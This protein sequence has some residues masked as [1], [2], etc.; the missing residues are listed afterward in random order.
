[1]SSSPIPSA[2]PPSYDA[3]L[4]PA[5]GA[6]G[7]PGE[8]KEAK[9]LDAAAEGAPQLPGEGELAFLKDRITGIQARP[10]NQGFF[11]QLW[12]ELKS[13][14]GRT[15]SS[16]ERN[17]KARRILQEP[18]Q[19]GEG[20]SSDIKGQ[21]ALAERAVT[22]AADTSKWKFQLER[23]RLLLIDK[24]FEAAQ[25]ALQDVP[26]AERAA[27]EYV[28]MKGV[29][30]EGN[31]KI[32]EA[33]ADYQKLSDAETKVKDFAASST[34]RLYK[35]LR[36]NTKQLNSLDGLSAA[37]RRV[38][39]ETADVS[40]THATNTLLDLLWEDNTPGNYSRWATLALRV[41]GDNLRFKDTKKLSD[42]YNEE[43]GRS[44]E[45]A[46]EW[47]NKAILVAAPD[48]KGELYFK[49]FKLH[50]SSLEADSKALAALQM[51]AHAA[52]PFRDASVLYNYNVGA[53]AKAKHAGCLYE[54]GE[55]YRKGTHGLPQNAQSATHNYNEAYKIGSAD[56]ATPANKTGAAA[57]AY[58]RGVATEDSQR[59]W[60]GPYKREW[61]ERAIRLGNSDAMYA[62]AQIHLKEHDLAK[63]ASLLRDAIKAGQP[64]AMK[65][66]VLCGHIEKALIGNDAEA[67]YQVGIAYRNGVPGLIEK[68]F[69]KGWEWLDKAAAKE[70]PEALFM[71]GEY[72]ETHQGND[73]DNNKA[74]QFYHRAANAGHVGALFRL[75]QAQQYGEIG[76]SVNKEIAIAFY[77]PAADKLPKQGKSNHAALRLGTLFKE[78]NRA[79]DNVLAAK[80]FKQAADD[81]YYLGQYEYGMCLLE[82]RGVAQNKDAGLALLMTS[83][84]ADHVEANPAR[85]ALGDYYRGLGGKDNIEKARGYYEQAQKGGE[86]EASAKLAALAKE[87]F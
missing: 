53:K 17:S 36:V 47:L 12:E 5:A 38:L 54:L 20:Q 83:A 42:Y 71:S 15:P 85:M 37:E 59:N 4:A 87:G 56:G 11:T 82:G 76:L 80:Y 45:K 3:P 13:L 22:A 6:P 61:F 74:V 9:A 31:K 1:M 64:E 58:Q 28:L 21:I 68:D 55:C 23:A 60:G 34:Q 62:M 70:H 81:R 30:H 86:G 78:R 39:A 26:E 67:L 19:T 52:P 18:V 27:P 49:L 10:L 63:A 8:H 57:A 75:G 73:R 48:Q 65:H 2:P 41:P 16:Y 29:A 44:V 77:Q 32:A 72:Y 43:P 46:I 35:T 33:F 66:Q 14:F 84:G 79:G 24:Q 69:K 51:A 7:G 50:G 40:N 25:Q